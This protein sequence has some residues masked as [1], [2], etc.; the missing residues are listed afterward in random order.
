[1]SDRQSLGSNSKITVIGSINCDFTSFLDDFPV[2]NQTTHANSFAFNV[3]GKGLNQAVAA[4]R[5]GAQV[6]FV[7][8]IGG[9][10]FG[11][12][13]L[14]YLNKH[15]VDTTHVYTL[16]EETTG[17][18]GIYV[19]SKG[20]NMIAVTP[21]ANACLTENHVQQAKELIA[22]SDVILVQLEIPYDTVKAALSLAR[23]SSTR[24]ILN[25]AP[26]TAC[27]S[28]LIALTDI[29][30]PNETEM[31]TLCGLDL[32]QSRAEGEFEH[33]SIKEMS[34]ELLAKGV[35]TVVTT[36]GA[37]G[38]YIVTNDSSKHVP[39]HPVRVLDP[40]GAGDVFNGVL[41]V[42]IAEGGSLFDAAQIAVAAAALSVEKETV[43][44]AAPTRVE[45][46][47]LLNKPPN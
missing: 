45:V 38:C 6:S 44:D 46:E 30:T 13:A 21:G 42:A 28:D 34:N 4:A 18:A 2:T 27:A 32:N 41:A 25:P 39:S 3:G 47:K 20:D 36:L 12:D 14:K 10:S 33:F 43:C 16:D 35:S 24:T 19:S 31:A 11:N 22:S 8:C 40:T 5:F 7:G 1:M 26:M 23:L 29:V 17:T 9:D 37:E 15:S